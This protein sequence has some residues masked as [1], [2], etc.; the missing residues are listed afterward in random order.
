MLVNADRVLSCNLFMTP[1]LNLA[2]SLY[3]PP[4]VK[5]SRMTWYQS[6]LI[7]P[8]KDY[9]R[10]PLPC[11][12]CHLLTVTLVITPPKLNPALSNLHD[13]KLPQASKPAVQPHQPRNRI[14]TRQGGICASGNEILWLVI[15]RADAG[16]LTAPNVSWVVGR[17]SC[18]WFKTE[19]NEA[20]KGI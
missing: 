6:S 2:T 20:W 18:E 1:P 19:V 12:P 4:H 16:G 13:R 8:N 5:A 7:Y 11:L 14:N 17:W 9:P 15:G 3:P 10:K